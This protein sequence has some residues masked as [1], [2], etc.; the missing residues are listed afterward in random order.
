MK[1]LIIALLFALCSGCNTATDDQY[2]RLLYWSDEEFSVRF[3]GNMTDAEVAVV[4]EK[5]SKTQFPA[6]ALTIDRMLPLTITP[7]A[8]V[9]VD[10]KDFMRGAPDLGAYEAVGGNIKDYWLNEKL[11]VRVGTVYYYSDDDYFSRQ[12]WYEFMTPE[13]AYRQDDRGPAMGR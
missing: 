8:R 9:F 3:V 10:G 2:A 4:R 1:L 13:Q 11:V 6:P 12:E 5:I 7:F